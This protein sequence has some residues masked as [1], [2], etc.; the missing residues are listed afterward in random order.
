MTPGVRCNLMAIRE[1]TL[2]LKG[3]VEDV[4]TDV[5]KCRFLIDRSE[6]VVVRIMTAVWSVESKFCE[7]R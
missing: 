3:P 4:R 7:Q 2:R 1:T 6:I 5:E